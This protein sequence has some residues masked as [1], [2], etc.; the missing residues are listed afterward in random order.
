[1]PLQSLIKR[2][3]R[4]LMAV[5][6]LFA[7]TSS[8]WAQNK[9]DVGTF[10]FEAKQGSHTAHIIFQTLWFD[11]NKHRVVIDRR[12]QTFV[13]RRPAFGTDG[14]IPSVEIASIKLYLDGRQIHIPRRLYA[15]CYQPH[16]AAL[17]CKVKLSRNAQVVTVEMEGADAAASYT[18]RWWF[19]K[20][21]RH[22]RTAYQHFSAEDSTGGEV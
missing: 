4:N 14:T 16:F 22:K 7:L 10:Q 13:D 19:N 12:N 9:N 1:M 6:F 11:R 8:A 17:F 15:D 18:V 3:F 21:G 20:N 2:M 5:S